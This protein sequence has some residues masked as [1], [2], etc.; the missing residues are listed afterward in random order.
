VWLQKKGSE[1]SAR[2]PFLEFE[3]QVAYFVA[4]GDVA[5]VVAIIGAAEPAGVVVA[6]VVFGASPPPQPTK[7][8]VMAKAMADRTKLR[9]FL[10]P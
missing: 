3:R 1:R 10:S 9:M 6:V 4:A 2:A 7:A 8:T 5:G